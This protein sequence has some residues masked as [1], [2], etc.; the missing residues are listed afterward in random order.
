MRERYP[1]AEI[2]SNVGL[3]LNLCSIYVCKSEDFAFEEKRFP[4]DFCER[5]GEAVTG[6]QS[7]GMIAL[8]VPASHQA[9]NLLL[10]RCR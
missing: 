3:G 10:L 7:C 9:S 5:V 1:D 8:A 6:V 4:A 2:V